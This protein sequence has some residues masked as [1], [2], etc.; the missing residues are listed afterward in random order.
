MSS[1]KYV[2]CDIEATGLD[3]DR[4]LIEIALITWENGHVIEVYQTLINPLRSIPEFISNLTSISNRSLQAAPKFYE[5]ADAIRVRLEGAIFVSHNTDFDLGLL[6]KKYQDMG[7]ELK[8]KSFCT[9]K[10]SQEEIP[11]LQNYNLDALCSFFDIKILQRHTAVG[12]AMATMELFKKLM[13]LRFKTYPKILYLPQHEKILKKMS[14]KAGLVFFKDHSEKVIHLEACLNM[15][16]TSRELLMIKE[17]NKNLLKNTFS[18]DT[19]VT[20]SALIAEFKKLIINP[21]NPHWVIVTQKLLSG[22]VIFKICP[23]KRNLSGLWYFKNHHDARTK[24]KFLDSELRQDKF[25]YRECSVSKEEILKHNQKVEKLSKEARFPTDDLIIMGEGRSLDE[26]SI[27]LVRNNH[28]IGYGYT[29]ASEENIF[30]QPDELIQK[31][32][33]KDLGIDIAAKRYIKI[34]K[35]MKHKTESWKTLVS[36]S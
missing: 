31:K 3:K 35:N 22:E 8:L 20:G 30:S 33:F 13:Q 32:F 23:N 5:L 36:L 1:N 26:K 27:I 10:V 11:G 12:D 16:K 21:Y 34:L 24:L 7:Q 29:N 9:L 19:E 6:Q 18:L 28:V 4:D 2:I 15:E 17:E 14:Q 25:I